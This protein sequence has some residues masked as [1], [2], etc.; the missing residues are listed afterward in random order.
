MFFYK[1][2]N[3]FSFKTINIQIDDLDYQNEF[4]ILN[5]SNNSHFNL[6][7][8][9]KSIENKLRS[10]YQLN[11]I[12]LIR[13]NKI[14]YPSKKYKYQGIIKINFIWIDNHNASIKFN[15]I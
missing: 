10:E 2:K 11:I 13:D 1:N 15:L 14:Y 6:I 12:P 9:I 4:L 8:I 7:Q 3:G 5:P